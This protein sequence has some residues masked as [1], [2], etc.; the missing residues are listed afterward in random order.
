[1]GIGEWSHSIQFA[2]DNT[3]WI[4]GTGGN[5]YGGYIIKS[6]DGGENWTLQMDLEPIGFY[7]LC[8]V[9]SNNIWVVGEA[10]IIYNTTDSG[11][12]WVTKSSGLTTG[13]SDVFFTDANTGWVV[14]GFAIEGW[15]KGLQDS[16]EIPII[17]KT[18]NGG[19]D[20]ETQLSIII[21]EQKILYSVY[22]VEENTGW[23][24]SDF[25]EI[26]HTTNGGEDWIN[27][28]GPS[29]EYPHK[30]FFVDDLTGWIIRPLSKTTDGGENWFTQS[31]G[32][33]DDLKGLYFINNEIGWVVSG[34]WNEHEGRIF[35]TTDGGDSWNVQLETSHN[36]G[37]VFFSDANNGWAAGIHTPNQWDKG[38]LYKTTNGGEDWIEY[39]GM[40]LP[41]LYNLFFTDVNNG[42]VLGSTESLLHTTNG[43]ADWNYQ[44]TGYAFDL[45]SLFF[46][47]N[48]NG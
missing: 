23:V 14:G 15:K 2:D 7:S 38:V 37:S 13:F 27:Q 44:S 42:W 35:K 6:T 32:T 40:E 34:N 43:G 39:T 25:G 4:V 5:G 30:I 11:N 26:L 47:D 12:N 45:S 33:N 46:A 1:M 18:T 29:T 48:N 3:G 10:G 8:C 41:V 24:V 19:N 9:N 21:P 31:T 16:T 20:W 17:I 36:F 22:F 28:S